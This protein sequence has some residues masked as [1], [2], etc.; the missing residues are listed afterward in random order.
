MGRMREIYTEALERGE[1][2]QAF[3]ETYFTH[4]D[5]AQSFLEECPDDTTEI[6]TTKP[7]MGKGKTTLD[8]SEDGIEVVSSNPLSKGKREWRESNV[9]TNRVPSVENKDMTAEETT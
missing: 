5:K 2:P 8:K 4:V 1:D 6:P 3:L 9:D 7:I